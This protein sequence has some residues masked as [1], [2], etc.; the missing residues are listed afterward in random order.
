MD[1]RAPLTRDGRSLADGTL[2]G[3]QVMINGNALSPPL[4]F[5]R[6]IADGADRGPGRGLYRSEH[7]RPA[8]IAEG[9]RTP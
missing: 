8:A 7:E 3:H 6:A 9:N 1:R 4:S 5:M 2:S